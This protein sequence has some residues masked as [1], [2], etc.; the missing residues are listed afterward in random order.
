MEARE[1]KAA[2][3]AAPGRSD[4][5]PEEVLAAFVDRHAGAVYRLAISIVRDPGLAE[6]VMQETLIKVWKE[7]PSWRGDAPFK[8]WVL[9]IAHNTAVS[10][11]RTLKE[12]SRDPHSLPQRRSDHQVEQQVQDRLMIE[13]ALLA[14]EPEARSLVVLRE[15]EGLSYDDI[16]AILE[17]PLPTVKTRLFRTRRAMQAKVR[18]R[19]R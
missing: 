19:S 13:E 5:S 9:K 8:H 7:L 16:S 2:F 15:I 1:S 10:T 17:L 6:D 14:L 12:E 18:R 11:L 3:A 4:P